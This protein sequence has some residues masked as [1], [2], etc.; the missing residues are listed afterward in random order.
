LENAIGRVQENQE[1][2]EL[3]ATHHLMFD[4]DDDDDVDITDK[5]LNTINEN[6]KS[7]LQASRED[8]LEINTKKTIWL[9]FIT[10]CRTNSQFNGC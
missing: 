7:L 8:R 10:K 5:H 4:D 6:T 2:L 9:C 3:T 1:H